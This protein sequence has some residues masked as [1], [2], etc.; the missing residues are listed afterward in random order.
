MWAYMREGVFPTVLSQGFALVTGRKSRDEAYAAIRWRVN[1]QLQRKYAAFIQERKDF[2]GHQKLNQYRSRKVWVCW[3]QGLDKAPLLVK[4]C[5]A[6]MRRWLKEREIVLLTGDNYREYAELPQSVVEK[7]EKGLMPAALFS[8]LLRLEVLIRYGGTWMDAT[9]LCTGEDFPREIMD[10]DL[11][12]FQGIVRGDNRFHGVSNWFITACAENRLL[13]VLRDVLL[14]YW[15][16]Y[17]VTL[18]YYMFHDFFYTIA[19]LYPAEIAEMPRMNR[20]WP[21][22]LMARMGDGFDNLWWEQLKAN[23]CFHKL[24]YRLS[25]DVINNPKNFYNVIIHEG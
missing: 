1:G 23:T 4:V 10:C 9:M 13:L 15:K 14:E 7:Y 22:Q 17:S 6:S 8:D 2:Y 20:L 24:N 19:Q 21:L 3:L 18:N 16:D 25:A 11:F 5:V 12:M